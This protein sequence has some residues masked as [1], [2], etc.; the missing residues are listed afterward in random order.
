MM[1]TVAVFIALGGGAYAAFS[2]P[3]N[4]VKSKHIVNGQVKPADLSAKALNGAEDWH[5]ADFD[6]L[7]TFC[8]WSNYGNGQNDAAYFRDRAGVVHLRGVVRVSDGASPCTFA[9]SQEWHLFS[10]P[11]GY[12]PEHNEALATTSNNAAA[13]INVKHQG[14]NNGMGSVEIEPGFPTVANAKQWVSLDGISFRCGPSGQDG[15]P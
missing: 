2:L 14:F 5:A 10:L 6:S 4:S 13:R 3:K 9:F 12:Q 1:A 11:P 7:A 8:I 15:C